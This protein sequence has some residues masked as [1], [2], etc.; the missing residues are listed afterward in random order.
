MGLPDDPSPPAPSP[1]QAGRGE[2]TALRTPLISIHKAKHKI[3]TPDRRG[4]PF[5]PGRDQGA[6]PAFR[7]SSP[8]PL[9]PQGEGG[10]R[11]LRERNFPL[12]EGEGLRVRA[13]AEI[14]CRPLSSRKWGGAGS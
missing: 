3:P 11:S 7:P 10:N 9:L 5:T 1:T 8:C 14:S 12:P 13:Y 4:H 2:N 6:T